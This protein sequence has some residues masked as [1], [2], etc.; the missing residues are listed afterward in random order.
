MK[1]LNE[2]HAPCSVH[3]PSVLN[4]DQP[5]FTLPQANE[6]PST[7]MIL[8]ASTNAF[9]LPLL[10]N[11][12]LDSSKVARFFHRLNVGNK[13]LR[14][15]LELFQEFLGSCDLLYGVDIR[16]RLLNARHNPH[17]QC[18]L[19]SR[20]VPDV[21]KATAERSGRGESIANYLFDRKSTRGR[22]IEEFC[23]VLMCCL[24]CAP[25]PTSSC[26]HFCSKLEQ[27]HQPLLQ[28]HFFACLSLLTRNARC[29]GRCFV[30][31]PSESDAYATQGDR[32]LPQF[33]C[34]KTEEYRRSHRK[35]CDNHRPGLPPDHAPVDAWRHA[36]AHPVP[37]FA[38]P[39][40]LTIPSWTGRQFATH[41]CPGEEPV[42]LSTVKPP[43]DLRTRLREDV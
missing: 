3:M 19:S 18:K 17:H 10:C 21:V 39:A 31:C 41:T 26:V 35:N 24:L 11:T 33:Q 4:A 14:K 13:Q 12:G 30:C 16:K 28:L 25:K 32:L 37:Q 5:S 1:V 9:S 7:F 42:S 23:R 8:A 43:R 15:S 20:R 27:H 40:H 34:H 36:W 22:L 29:S 2:A 6:R 38:E